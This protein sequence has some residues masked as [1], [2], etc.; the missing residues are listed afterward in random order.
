M[1]VL[2]L[3]IPTAAYLLVMTIFIVIVLLPLLGMG[4][5]HQSEFDPD[6]KHDERRT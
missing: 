5:R 2:E 3:S 6:D 4:L 1:N